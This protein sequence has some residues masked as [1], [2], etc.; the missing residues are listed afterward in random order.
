M[1]E[2]L[3]PRETKDGSR[4]TVETNMKAMDCPEGQ[5][6]LRFG[7]VVCLNGS[8]YIV[9]HVNQSGA[10][11]VPE[12]ARRVHV[13]TRFGETKDFVKQ[14]RGIT[15]SKNIEPDCIVQHL[16]EEV[17]QNFFARKGTARGVEQQTSQ[18]NEGETEMRKKGQTKRKPRGGLAADA[19]ADAAANGGHVGSLGDVFGFS[20]TGVM[21][22]LGREGLKASQVAAVMKEKG[23]KASKNTVSIQVNAGKNGVTA[24]KKGKPVTYPELTKDQIKEL[25]A[26]AP[27]EEAKE[28]K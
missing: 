2:T 7:D 3:F 16:S 6:T 26:L 25:V 9:K 5:T 11:C 22:V 10:Y 14:E 20:A 27:A 21:R 8:R 1:S 15:I 18:P 17:A 13:E 4:A 28:G 23:V 19:A 24:G 12:T